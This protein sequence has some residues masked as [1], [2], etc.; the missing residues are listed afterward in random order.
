M[1]DSTKQETDDL[2]VYCDFDGTIAQKDVGYHL[3]SHFSEIGNDDLVELWQSQKI[4]ARECLQIEV[5][6]VKAP[7]EEMI[8]Y[9]DQFKL[10][11]YFRKFVETLRAKEI[12]LT[13][14]SDGLDFYIKYLLNKNGFGA[15]ELHT[16]QAIV[17]ERSLE[18]R[19]PYDDGCDK[20]G[21]CK[22]ERIRALNK[23]DEFSGQTVFIGDGY[24]DLCAVSE[25][26]ILFAKSD[27]S[28]YCDNARLPY[29][30]YEN[31]QDVLDSL[32][33]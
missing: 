33:I 9:I 14:L 18:V 17:G 11:P 27:L 1:T 25:A 22:G 6:R 24:S 29:R 4:G 16:N 15:I 20:C 32:F 10:D 28:R 13:L 2:R 5:S 8:T 3:L 21:T 12:K 31:F 26:D 30:P 19:F 23:R 7:R